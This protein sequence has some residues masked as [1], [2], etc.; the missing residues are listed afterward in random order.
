MKIQIYFDKKCI[1]QTQK[2]YIHQMHIH[3]STLG[4]TNATLTLSQVTTHE[5]ALVQW[6]NTH[7]FDHV[8]TLAYREPTNLRN[9]KNESVPYLDLKQT[10]YDSSDLIFLI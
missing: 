10:T 7:Q 8:V 9:K 4:D 6:L 3:R 5:V 1:D 2:M